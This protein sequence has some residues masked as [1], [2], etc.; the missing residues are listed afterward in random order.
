MTIAV[1]VLALTYGYVKAPIK[2]P[3]EKEMSAVQQQQKTSDYWFCFH[4]ALDKYKD[5]FYVICFSH[6]NWFIVVL[7][8]AS[9][10]MPCMLVT[11]TFTSYSV[12]G[13]Y[14]K[15][16]YQMSHDSLVSRVW[17][18]SQQYFGI[19]HKTKFKI[20]RYF[21]ILTFSA[22]TQNLIQMC[23]KLYEQLLIGNTTTG[24]LG[25]FI[26]LDFVSF[27]LRL[28]QIIGINA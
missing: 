6:Y 16:N 22:C 3:N 23:C 14:S 24:Y 7:L 13:G 9:I 18:V 2:H 12:F 25:F 17:N 19:N 21:Y 4:V 11:S 10:F 1:S 15:I 28:G 26:F 5:L 27:N 8:W 20:N